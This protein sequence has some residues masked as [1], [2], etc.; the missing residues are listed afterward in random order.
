MSKATVRLIEKRQQE[1]KRI[2]EDVLLNDMEVVR[3][4]VIESYDELFIALD[5]GLK[6]LENTET[7]TLTTYSDLIQAIQSVFNRYVEMTEPIESR[8]IR[9]FLEMSTLPLIKK[10]KCNEFFNELATTDL[11]YKQALATLKRLEYTLMNRI[12]EITNMV[13]DE[14]WDNLQAILDYYV[15]LVAIQTYKIREEQEEEKQQEQGNDDKKERVFISEIKK[16]TDR[17]ELLKLANK[18]GYDF[19]RQTG[20]HMILENDRGK[21]VVI[22]IHDNDIQRGLSVKIQKDIFRNKFTD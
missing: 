4:E 13:I 15:S 7:I 19:K 18:N 5:L 16:I 2:C 14:I 12:D 22:P 1:I 11:T 8:V 21:V 10:I 6:A 9:K 3:Q 17:Q 20:S